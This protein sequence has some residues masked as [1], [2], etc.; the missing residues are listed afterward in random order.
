MSLVFLGFGIIGIWSGEEKSMGDYSDEGESPCCLAKNHSFWIESGSS[1]TTRLLLMRI[2]RGRRRERQTD[3][4]EQTRKS[5]RDRFRK[6][7]VK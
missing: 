1:N 3:G 5:Q 2:Y 6:R 4:I 7:G